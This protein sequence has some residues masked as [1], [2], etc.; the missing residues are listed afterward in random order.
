MMRTFIR[1]TGAATLALLVAAPA[2]AQTVQGLQVGFGA[3]SP[4]GFD[5]RVDEDTLV[6]NLNAF[7]PLLFEIGDFKG[8]TVFGEW[9]V[10]FGDHVE[11]AAGVGYYS[12][13]VPSIYENLIDQQ[14]NSE[15]A[16]RL[17]LRVVP[18]TG[19]V[20]FLPF[21]RMGDF[22]PYIGGGVGVLNWRYTEIGEFVDTFDDSIFDGRFVSSG[23]TV[24][25]VFL[26]GARIP[27]R[28]DIYALTFE[29]RYQSG[30]GD[31]GGLANDFL[32][33]K[34]DLSGGNFN[35]GFLIRF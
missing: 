4:R 23:T 8:A 6:A 24:G 11:V 9:L 35:F 26:G 30:S 16:Q 27:I 21:G 2:W 25:P 20:R 28:G 34:I 22:Q 32:G 31:T 7:E 5:S 14:D 17:K 1:L 13:S 33:E 18:V 19:V 3:F 12:R 10:A 29:Y 15:I